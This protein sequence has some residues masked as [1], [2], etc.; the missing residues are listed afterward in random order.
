MTTDAADTADTG[1]L[2]KFQALLRDLF[3]FDCADLDFGIYR[4]MNHKR[5]VVERFVSENLP[6]AV[7]AELDTG[8]LRDQGQAATRLADLEQQVR[9][10]LGPDAIGPDGELAEVYRQSKIGQDY[11]EA[12]AATSGGTDR[13][14]VEAAVY[15]HL[16]TFF[17][18]Y[19]EDGDFIS[20]RRYGR[21]QRYA[22]PYNG[23]EVY[24]HWANSDQYYVKTEEN[25]R[26]YDWN[27]PNGVSVRFRLADANI[28]QN[29][30]KGDKR[31]FVPRAR[32]TRYDADARVVTI[33]FE[34]R[35]LNGA[36]STRYRNRNQQ[37][38]IIKEAVCAIPKRLE[39]HTEA[40]DALTGEHRRNPSATPRAG[41]SPSRGKGDAV[42]RLRHHLLRYTR[43]NDSDF[44]IHK[45][46][47]GFLTRELDFYLKNEVL[48][49]DDLVA[50]GERLAEGR[51]QQM[52]LIKSIGG[53][54]IDFLAQ[55]EDFQKTLWEKRKFV[56]DVQYCVTLAH[57]DAAFHDEITANDAQWAEWRDLLGVD[58]SRR[59]PAF[60]RDN[61]TL[62]LDTAHFGAG[63]TDRL[64]AS[65]RPTWTA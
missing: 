10:V 2:R 58:D 13:A 45:A 51:F 60:L 20:K 28:E 22:I 47:S 21:N 52:P 65:F 6:A 18:R 39:A 19:Y 36:E 53:K 64:L 46:L 57:V 44:F 15:N 23:E 26:D 41:S 48:N 63:F 43:K 40:V 16:H 29:N 61:P 9:K 31:F 5:D 62:P 27:A 17:S 32:E 11:L 7:A 4:I 14:A 24:L 56:T 50:A 55:I 38:N 30:V 34:Y 12:R 33:P 35:P 1:Q 59:N 25:F 37:D 42:S 49:I 8:A 3:Q 54:I